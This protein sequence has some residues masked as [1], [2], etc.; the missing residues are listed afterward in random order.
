MSGTSMIR[1]ATRL[2]R[3]GWYG[4]QCEPSE[5][6]IFSTIFVLLLLKNGLT[7][8]LLIKCALSHNSFENLSFDLTLTIQWQKSGTAIAELRK[9]FRI[10][11]RI[12]VDLV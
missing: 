8:Q 4:K 6:E 10:F 9:D 5:R 11:I 3:G 12:F 7:T 2:Q 1:D